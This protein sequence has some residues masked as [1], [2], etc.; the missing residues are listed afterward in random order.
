[1]DQPKAKIRQSGFQVFETDSKIDIQWE[2][3]VSR[4]PDSLIYHHPAWLKVLEK[5]SKQIAIRLVCMNSQKELK[6]V[7]PLL[8]TRGFPFGIGGLLASRRLSSLP[9]TPISGPLTVDDEATRVLIEEAIK[10]VRH[11]KGTRLQ[12]KT[13]ASHLRKVTKDLERVPWRLT[14]LKE[15]PQDPAE[16]RFGNSRRHSAILRAIKKANHKGIKIRAGET[17]NDL[18]AWY[19]LYLETM[20]WH[21]VPARSFHFFKTL[22]RQ[23]IPKK[24]IRLLLAELHSGDDV[25]LLAGSIFLMFNKTVFYAF[26]GSRREDFLLRPNDLLH[27]HAMQVA[28]REGYLYY[29]LGEAAEKHHGLAAY[30][31][32]WSSKTEQLYHYYYPAPLKT[33]TVNIDSENLNS[34]KRAIW[35]KLPLPLTGFLGSWIYKYL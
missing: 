16:I 12:F 26:N 28:S 32:K 35:Q 19:A 20:R 34:M 29:D 6:G 14:Y 22:W 31:S 7:L 30:K 33:E 10:I 17:E 11:R 5:E 13:N 8:P 4:H 24:F 27:W 1:M 15:L 25:R 23:L 18:K 3:F 2:D 9:R 21:S